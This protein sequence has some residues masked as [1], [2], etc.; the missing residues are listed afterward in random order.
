MLSRDGKRRVVAVA[1]ATIGER[2]ILVC[3]RQRG[4]QLRG[5]RQH[6]RDAEVAGADALLLFPPF[7]WALSQDATMS[8]TITAWSP[9]RRGCR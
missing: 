5:S 2:A 7:S 1:Q 6:A 3:G 4:G 9:R 8:L